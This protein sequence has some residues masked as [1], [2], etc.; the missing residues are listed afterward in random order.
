LR[1]LHGGA[2]FVLVASE[3]FFVESVGGFGAF[4]GFDPG[5]AEDGGDTAV[6]AGRVAARRRPGRGRRGRA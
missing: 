5:T 6:D 3:V 2:L 1:A 4:E